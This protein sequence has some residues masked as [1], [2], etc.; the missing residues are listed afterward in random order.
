M[1]DWLLNAPL[2]IILSITYTHDI[3]YNLTLSWRRLLS[4]KNQLIDLLRKSVDWFLYDNGLRHE[5]VNITNKSGSCQWL[6]L[7]K[8]DTIASPWA[9]IKFAQNRKSNIY[10]A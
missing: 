3:K 1:F 5:R 9:K 4:Y 2:E 7:T 10:L 8:Y 6:F